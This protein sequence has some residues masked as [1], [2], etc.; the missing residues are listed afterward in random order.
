MKTQYLTEGVLVRPL[1]SLATNFLS[2]LYYNGHGLVDLLADT[3]SAQRWFRVMSAELGTTAGP[4]PHLSPEDLPAL[5]HL[6]NTVEALY[7]AT[8]AGDSSLVSSQLNREFSHIEINPHVRS[9]SQGV[10]LN[11]AGKSATALDNFIAEVLFSASFT[12]SPPQVSR[13]HKCD[14]PRCVLYY[15]QTHSKQHWCSST[16]GNRARVARHARKAAQES[17]L[18][19]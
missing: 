9:S 10:C 11:L 1:E 12:L 14:G 7:A 19:H 4:G 17:Q 5:G 16:C 2:S 6:R 8:V 3:D 13:L 15:A 18:P